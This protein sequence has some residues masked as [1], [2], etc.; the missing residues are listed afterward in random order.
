MDSVIAKAAYS[1]GIGVAEYFRI[2]Q[3]TQ[4]TKDEKKLA[5]LQSGIIAAVSTFGGAYVDVDTGSTAKA[6]FDTTVSSSKAGLPGSIASI[7]TNTVNRSLTNRK[8][9]SDFQRIKAERYWKA[10][11]DF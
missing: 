8:D 10:I 7:G 11:C 4:G 5:G 6:M 1:L 9:R 3:E 2:Y